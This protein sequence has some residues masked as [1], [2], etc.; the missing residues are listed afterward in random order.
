MVAVDHLEIV[1]NGRVVHAIPTTSD[2]KSADTTVVLDATTTGW[3]L[4]RAWS[5]SALH[6]VLDLMPMATTSPI[7]VRIADRP[8]VSHSDGR[9]FTQWITRLDS[10][11]SR[12]GSYNDPRERD[13]TLRT[14]RAA[15]EAMAR[16]CG[17]G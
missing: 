3:F 2:R 4:L 5:D 12:F 6:P 17:G 9:F 11:A 15:H 10:A 13:A 16:R 1:H 14:I 7:Y 8:Q